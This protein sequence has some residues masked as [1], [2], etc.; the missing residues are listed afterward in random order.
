MDECRICLENEDILRMISPCK[1]KGS[2][3]YIHVHC[4]LKE[5]RVSNRCECSICK[6]KYF[7]KYR[8][9]YQLI[10]KKPFQP[11]NEEIIEARVGFECSKAMIIM[12]LMIYVFY[13]AVIILNPQNSSIE[14]QIILWTLMILGISLLRN[15]I[16][17]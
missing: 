7:T 6:T 3:Q 5:L 4:F 1:C 12:Q 13:L 11:E 15:S 16:R 14:S 9:L 17:P 2:V 8:V 10:F